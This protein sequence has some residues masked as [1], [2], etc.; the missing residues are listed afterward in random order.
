MRKSARKSL[1]LKSE[2]GCGEVLCLKAENIGDF[3]KRRQSHGHES[4]TLL[5]T[6]FPMLPGNR[7][8][9]R[10]WESISPTEYLLAIISVL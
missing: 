8:Q 1:P 4:I 6:S 7:R 9:E 5:K 3:V 10:I 2:D